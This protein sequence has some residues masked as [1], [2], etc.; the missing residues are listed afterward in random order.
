MRYAK[1]L[2]LVTKY[3]GRKGE[4]KIALQV[5]SLSN[6]ENGGDTKWVKGIG[7]QSLKRRS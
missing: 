1:D 5:F 4:R 7:K 3:S 2:N 6:W